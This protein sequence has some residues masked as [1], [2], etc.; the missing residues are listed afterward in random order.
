MKKYEIMSTFCKQFLQQLDTTCKKYNWGSSWIQHSTILLTIKVQHIESTKK[1]KYA[2]QK[3]ELHRGSMRIKETNVH[4]GRVNLK[5]KKKV[6]R[7]EG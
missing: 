3:R 6:T 5:K 2:K 4:V 7:R 1:R